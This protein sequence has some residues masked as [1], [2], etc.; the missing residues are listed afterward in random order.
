M[1]FSGNN[2]NVRSLRKRK[3]VSNR[4]DIGQYL[5][6]ETRFAE[7]LEFHPRGAT[8]PITEDDRDRVSLTEITTMKFHRQGFEPGALMAGVGIS[9]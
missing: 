5:E 2:G 6:F 1:H 7:S 9:Q 4:T 8:R 3:I